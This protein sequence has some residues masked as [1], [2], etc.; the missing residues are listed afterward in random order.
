MSDATPMNPAP[1]PFQNTAQH[2]S[3]T[4]TPKQEEMPG[5]DPSVL[6]EPP[7]NTVK[8]EAFDYLKKIT[9][10]EAGEEFDPSPFYPEGLTQEMV[11]DFKKKYGFVELIIVAGRTWVYRM[12]TRS[13]Y[14]AIMQMQLDQ[15][16]LEERIALQGL[17]FPNIQ[18]SELRQMPAGVATSLADAILRFSGFGAQSVPILL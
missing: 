18:L 7:D 13:E 1:D 6:K 4:S 12:I 3:A 10:G 9:S 2:F 8:Q 17:L 11:D 15:Q 16:R 14:G 5:Y